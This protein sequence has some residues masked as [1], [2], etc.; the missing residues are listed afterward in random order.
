MK[1]DKHSMEEKHTE[2]EMPRKI[3]RAQMTL[4]CFPQS[5]GNAPFPPRTQHPAASWFPWHIAQDKE[6]VLKAM[7][8]RELFV[9]L[10]R[11][12]LQMIVAGKIIPLRIT[13]VLQKSAYGRNTL[14]VCQRGGVLFC[15]T[16][17]I[18]YP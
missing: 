7:G 6:E 10:H 1:L 11:R 4:T 14:Q 5:E 8:E 2:L 16:T 15:E 13:V 12:I 18:L 3:Q 17:V 9:T